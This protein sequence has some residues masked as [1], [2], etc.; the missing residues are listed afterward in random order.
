MSVQVFPSLPGLGFSWV[1]KPIWSTLKQRSVSGKR[2]ALALWSYPLYEWELTYEFI[3]SAAATPEWQQLQAFFN[4]R[5][6][7]FDTFLLTDPDDNS[8]AAQALG[9]G[10]GVTRDFQL[11]RALGGYVEPI[12]APNVI[13]YIKKAGVTVDPADYTV[14]PWGTTTPGNINFDTAPANGAAITA[15]FS[16]YFPV[17]FLEDQMEFEKFMNQLWELKSVGL[18]S[19]K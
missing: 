7:A 14:S 10:D 6:G 13:T 4:S 8:V 2:S 19:I 18:R 11:V 16:Y 15:S 1:R 12:L 3:R 17:E 5:Q 9:T